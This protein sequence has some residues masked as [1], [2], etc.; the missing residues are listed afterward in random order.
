M[1]VTVTWVRWARHTSASLASHAEAAYARSSVFDAKS[2]WTDTGL[3]IRPC[4]T[5]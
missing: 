5:L 4:S 1:R 2:D 3:S